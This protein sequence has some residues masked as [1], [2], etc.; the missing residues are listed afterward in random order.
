MK[1]KNG[2]Y[3]NSLENQISVDIEVEINPKEDILY[4]AQI[5]CRFLPDADRR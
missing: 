1:S 2:V 3:L 4:F 5:K